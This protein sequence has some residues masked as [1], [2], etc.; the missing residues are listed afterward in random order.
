MKADLGS[1]RRGLVWF[2]GALAL[3]CL[4][5]AL[6]PSPAGGSRPPTRT[7]KNLIRLAFQNAHYATD[8]GVKLKSIREIRVS[9][10]DQRWAS[11]IYKRGKG[12][13]KKRAG[14]ATDFFF[15]KGS[16]W[17]LRKKRQVPG[18][19]RQDLKQPAHTPTGRVR[20]AGSGTF[21]SDHDGGPDDTQHHSATFNWDVTWNDVLLYD[22]HYP[23][24][25][26]EAASTQGGGTWNLSDTGTATGSA[27]CT[28][29]G[30]LQPAIKDLY[31]DRDGH[32]EISLGFVLPEFI[33]LPSGCYDADFWGYI[34]DGTNT[35]NDLMRVKD[36]PFFPE[37]PIEATLHPPDKAYAE[38]CGQG[39]GY[40]CLMDFTAKV[41]IT[42]VP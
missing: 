14:T 5:V 35:D 22:E 3:V 11:A 36:I 28:A 38:D 39:P 20:Y 31:I 32:G 18:G 8:D 19:I 29:S 30:T 21:S 1:A 40:A 41:T 7:E 25:P 23:L 10:V 2:T 4:A 37:A 34:V 33:G 6:L 9:M 12:G 13:G 17:K 24:A 15:L 27:P 16:Q 42:P 26:Y